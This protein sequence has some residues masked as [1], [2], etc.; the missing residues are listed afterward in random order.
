MENYPK[1]RILTVAST[2]S[3]VSY[4]GNGSTTAFAVSFYFLANADLK[5]TL[6]SDDIEIDEKEKLY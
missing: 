6:A 1:E 5:V 3:K 4:S 2:T